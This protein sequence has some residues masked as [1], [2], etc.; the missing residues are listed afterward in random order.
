MTVVVVLKAARLHQ[1]MGMWCGE[2]NKKVTLP[3]P[4]PVT[5]F[6]PHEF[7][8]MFILILSMLLLEL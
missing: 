3:P 1:T 5:F 8:G 2:K 7:A 4:P 6:T